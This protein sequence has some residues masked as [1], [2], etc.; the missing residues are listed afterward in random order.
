MNYSSTV[1]KDTLRPGLMVVLTIILGVIL[2]PII[3]LAL[4]LSI[5]TISHSKIVS[6]QEG[7]AHTVYLPLV[8][9]SGETT[10][11]PPPPPTMSGAL[12][13]GEDSFRS[14]AIAVDDQGGM[15]IAF[16]RIAPLLPGKQQALFYGFCQP[17]SQA[18]CSDEADWQLTEVDNLAEGWPWVQLRLTPN[19]RPRLLLMRP[20][21][22]DGVPFGGLLYR[23]AECNTNCTAAQNWQALDI[24]DQGTGGGL[25]N[26]DYSYQSFALDHLGR[27]RFVYEDRANSAGAHA[28]AYYVF[29]D[30]SCT[31]PGT[32]FETRLDSSG[33]TVYVDEHAALMFTNNG[34]PRVFGRDGGSLADPSSKLVYIE[35]NTQCADSANWSLPAHLLSTNSGSGIYSWSPAVDENDGVRLTFTPRGGP[36]YYLWCHADCA[37][38][39]NWDGYS[40]DLG[41]GSGDYSALAL[42]RHG[43]PRVAYRDLNSFSLAYFWCDGLCESP[44]PQWHVT[45]AEDSAQIGDEHPISPLPT[46][47][48]GGWFGGLRPVL[49]LDAQDNPRFAYDAEYMMECLQNP[50]NPNDPSTYVEAKWW[51]ARFVFFP[52]PSSVKST[53]VLPTVSMMQLETAGKRLSNGRFAIVNASSR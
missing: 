20:I 10:P 39:E 38:T 14:A 45:L 26:T 50:G 29:C 25:Y 4:V 22:R 8:Q 13:F 30:G 18:D 15:H 21:S 12:M 16:S 7:P 48:R 27:P 46:C 23:Y 32:W 5:I 40:L 31:Q 47:V 24:T 3:I 33:D 35:C 41:G 52:Q 2:L 37:Q 34:R 49:A 43:R 17:A 44:N 53:S 6:A 28:G 9:G 36:F 11:P 42:D 1:H 51:T 19:G